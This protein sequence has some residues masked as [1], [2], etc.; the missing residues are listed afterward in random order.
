MKKLFFITIIAMSI[1]LFAKNDSKLLQPVEIPETKLIA[2]KNELSQSSEKND[3]FSRMA[4]IINIDNYKL[5]TKQETEII[6]TSLIK[7]NYQVWQVSNLKTLELKAVIDK[8]VS[9][10]Q[11]NNSEII[12][13][14]TGHGFSQNNNTFLSTTDGYVALNYIYQKISSIKK[15]K[16]LFL[17]ACRE[18][19]AGIKIISAN[20]ITEQIPENTFALFSSAIGRTAPNTTD[21]VKLITKAIDLTMELNEIAIY[22]NDRNTCK[23]LSPVL[24]STMNQKYY[25][26][27]LNK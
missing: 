7:N 11:T 15:V 25:I 8:F 10:A 27:P 26:T 19:K 9:N 1:N 22:I 23:C 13:Y 12:I 20:K 2:N 17:N 24:K 16:V 18:V 3:C 6:K 5:N 4:L 21:F 14:Y